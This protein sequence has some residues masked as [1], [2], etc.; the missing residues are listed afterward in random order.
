MVNGHVHSTIMAVA[1]MAPMIF[2]SIRDRYP[3]ALVALLFLCLVGI[4]LLTEWHLY[5]VGLDRDRYGPEM[6]RHDRIRMELWATFDWS[7]VMLAIFV[8][9]LLR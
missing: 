3:A 5:H 4:W 7:L 8:A 2:T 1:L 9:Y 6:S